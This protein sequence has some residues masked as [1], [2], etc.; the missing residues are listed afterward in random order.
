MVE[1]SEMCQ[2]V[3]EQMFEYYEK[4]SQEMEMKL[5]ELTE[6]LERSSQLGMELQRASQTLAAI[7]KGLQQ[8]P[9]Q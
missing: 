1:V 9:G 5:T 8:T 3:K 6:V 7:N 2:Q 4:H